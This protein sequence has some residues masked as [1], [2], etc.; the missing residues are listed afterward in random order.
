[1]GITRKL[2]KA[3]SKKLGSLFGST[4]KEIKKKLKDAD[5]GGAKRSRLKKAERLYDALTVDANR[6]GEKETSRRLMVEGKKS[7]PPL[8]GAT[9]TDRRG[10]LSGLI[11]E[12]R[13]INSAGEILDGEMEDRSDA[14]NAL[15]QAGGVGFVAGLATSSKKEV[16]KASTSKSSSI[17]TIKE[18]I[19]KEKS[20]I[21]KLRK[22]K[23]KITAAD[24]KTLDSLQKRLKDLQGKKKKK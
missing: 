6:Y 4:A 24:L 15:L 21:L 3:A 2:S 23:T 18:K 19:K 20:R 13:I 10:T 8:P 14:I 12:Q 7:G 9:R 11:G 22:G 16:K 5:I 17:E 1:M